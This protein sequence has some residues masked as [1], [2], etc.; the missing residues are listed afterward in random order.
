MKT[1]VE[2]FINRENIKNFKKR[3]EGPI[4]EAQ[5]KTLLALLAEE[6]AKAEQLAKQAGTERR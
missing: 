1:S 5:R 6:E 4:N 2:R 3:L